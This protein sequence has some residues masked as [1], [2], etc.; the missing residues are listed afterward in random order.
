MT[1]KTED[2]FVLLMCYT[3]GDLSHGHLLCLRGS[4]PSVNNWSRLSKGLLIP[5][6]EM[7]GSIFC[8]WVKDKPSLVMMTFVEWGN[9]VCNH[10]KAEM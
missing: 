3:I 2:T 10:V 8:V 6:S 5:F 9:Q 4:C 1:L 7:F